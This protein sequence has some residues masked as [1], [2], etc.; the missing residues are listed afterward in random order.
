MSDT[1]FIT[2]A[3]G[4][5]G[6]A[7][8]RHLLDRRVAPERIVAGTRHPEKLAD[9][10]ARGVTVR[11]A[12]FDDVPGLTSAF[13]GAGTV[14]IISTDVLTQDGHRLRQHRNA[15]QAAVAAGV[16]HLAYTS[17]PAPETSPISFAPDHALTEEAL[18]ATGLPVTVFRNGWYH[19]N[20]FMSVP[21]ALRSGH[22]YTASEQGRTSYAARDEIAEAIAAVLAEAPSGSRTY[23]LTGSEAF[24]VEEIAALVRTST[25]KPLDVVH[26]TDDQLAA[27]LAAAGVPEGIVPILVSME[28]ATRAGSLGIVTDDLA[29]ILG[30]TPTSL[31]AFIADKAGALSG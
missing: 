28:V 5:L 4:H 12:D 26:V 11:K 19:E 24:T 29:T 30:R 2:G 3:A 25:G 6:G 22:W 18:H 1:I 8:V 20:L 10:A 31:Q 9:L 14:L 21:A 15:V 23:T 27:G 13:A 16:R 7:V 17:L